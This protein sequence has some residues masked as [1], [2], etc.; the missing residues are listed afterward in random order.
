MNERDFIFWLHGWLEIQ[1]PTIIT[2]AQ[3]QEIKN[4]IDLV[5][6][7]NSANF[8]GTAPIVPS[9]IKNFNG[10]IFNNYPTFIPTGSQLICGGKTF[11]CGDWVNGAAISC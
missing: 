1:N 4:H 10:P 6:K 9:G 7:R 3:V 2:T 8:I 5:L 11:G